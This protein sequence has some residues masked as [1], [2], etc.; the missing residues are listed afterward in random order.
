MSEPALPLPVT[1]LTP[2]QQTSIVNLVRR[3]ARAEILPR[4]RNLSP[5]QISTKSSPTDLVTEADT[6]AE[7]MIAR[8]ILHL[9]PNALVLGEE[10]ASQSPELRKQAAEA[11]LAFIV[12][13]VDGTWNF[14]HGVPLFGVILAATRFGKPIFGL[15]YDP[16][17]DDWVI[18]SEDS[19]ARHA[20]LRGS[21]ILSMGQGGALDTLSGHAHVS[22]MPR[23]TQENLAPLLPAFARVGSLRCSCHEYRMAAQGAADFVLSGLLNPWDHA[24][25][26]L[27]CQRA[28]GHAAFLDGRDYDIS[29]TEGQLLVAATRDT[30]N[31]IRDHLAPV[32]SPARHENGDAPS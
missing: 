28:G 19:P 21:K 31:R 24:A 15:L 9:F 16:I 14:A 3:A 1:T 25:G 10:T 20:D 29:V 11:E 4:F 7:A 6:E 12:D 23:D 2:A 27:I 26:V 17:C 18:A 30:W 8:G 32:L 22:L 13:P 5:A